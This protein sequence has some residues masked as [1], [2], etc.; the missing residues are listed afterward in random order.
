[1]RAWFLS[2][3]GRITLVTT[4]VAVLAVLVTGLLSL[5][6]VRS[7][8]LS[9]AR[10]QLAGQA[11][12]LS[13]RPATATQLADQARLALG[14]TE[15]AV[16]SPGGAVTGSAARYVRPALVRA[17]LAGDTV[18]RVERR[19]AAQVA[20]EGRPTAA[21]GAV[22]LVRSTEDLE[23]PARQATRR[24]LIGLGVGI[25]VAVAAGALLGRWIARP[26]AAA[27]A[28]ARRMAAGERDLPLPDRGAT[29]IQDVG[30]ALAALD[31]A[32][33]T[34]EARQREFLLSISHDLRTPLTALR[35][36]GEA[37]ADGVVA[38]ADT[39]TVGATLVAETDRLDRFVSDL[40]ELARLE[41]DDF[42]I[43]P[44]SVD[45]G[46]VL[47]AVREAWSGHS[48]T[49]GV[50][51]VVDAAPLHLITDGQRVRQVLDGLVEN[52]LRVSPEGSTVSIG[53]ERH[54]TT[55]RLTVTDGGPGLSPDDEAHAFERGM[56]HTKYRDQRPV[57][58]GLGLSIAARLVARMGGTIAAG[59]AP[60][61]G[62]R[63]TVTLPG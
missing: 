31:S 37:L 33:S 48:A 45:L 44:Q 58:T 12:L 20:L 17:L 51:V 60:G 41:A 43:H 57:G 55:V 3:G 62:A 30:H 10:G 38:A 23:G 7:S 61:G 22:V 6:L 56:L 28:S 53:A 5:Q 40:L 13:K 8:S 26:L 34:S 19:A 36:Y 9:E 52:A 29:E 32:L 63:F 21:G 15:V 18:S 4:C 49:L 59:A 42:A 1:M 2:L 24:I 46:G 39:A 50:T 16:I 47:A 14:D 11:L 27:A 35:G 54:G 25:L